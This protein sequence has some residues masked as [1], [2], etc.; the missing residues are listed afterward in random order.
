MPETQLR[1][2]DDGSHTLF[3]PHFGET[4]H[5][6]FGAIQESNHVFIRAGLENLDKALAE[7]KILE[8][9][10]GTGL[11]ALL[12]LIWASEHKKRI[13]YFG[14][15]AFPPHDDVLKRINYPELL[16]IDRLLFQKLHDPAGTEK[17]VTPEFT[18]HVAFETVQAVKLPPENFDLVYFDAF[19]PVAQPEMWSQPIF[20]KLHEAMKPGGFLTTYSSSG[21]VKRALR[22]S[23]FRIARLSGPPGKREMLRASKEKVSG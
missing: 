12:S 8:V 21:M 23:G 3:N 5:S 17:R 7:I 4:Y 15:E 14:I 1:I 6:S 11:N 2:T 16:K 18:L 22:A 19:S 13:R 10:F 9:G 20:R